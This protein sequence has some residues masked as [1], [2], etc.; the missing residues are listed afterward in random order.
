MLEF[1]I[2]LCLGLK[3]MGH[4]AAG[5]MSWLYTFGGNGAE[6]ALLNSVQTALLLLP[7]GS[8]QR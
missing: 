2:D 5:E 3:V 6:I 4:Q 7:A 1:F 8:T